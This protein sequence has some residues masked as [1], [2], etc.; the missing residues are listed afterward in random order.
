MK[1]SEFQTF[2]G[3]DD[4]E[5]SML[6][7]YQKNGKI[8]QIRKGTFYDTEIS[9]INQRNDSSTKSLFPSEN[10]ENTGLPASEWCV[11]YNK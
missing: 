11:Y 4:Q 10:K 8:T 9:K 2:Y 1:R 5:M 6:D 3:F 7:I